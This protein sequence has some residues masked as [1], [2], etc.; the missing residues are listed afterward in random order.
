M[1]DKQDLGKMLENKFDW[2]QTTMHLKKDLIGK[3]KKNKTS[4]TL[5]NINKAKQALADHQFDPKST[6]LK[7]YEKELQLITNLAQFK[8]EL[9]ATTLHKFEF[10][11]DC[12]KRNLVKPSANVK[13]RLFEYALLNN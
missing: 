1:Q 6:D 11:F 7:H 10:V 12:M 13:S 5:K 3:L 4:Q 9:N 8:D 2:S